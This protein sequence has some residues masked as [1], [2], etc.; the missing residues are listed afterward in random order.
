MTHT[1]KE[2]DAHE[3]LYKMDDKF[4]ELW[5]D[6]GKLDALANLI[7]LRSDNQEWQASERAQFAVYLCCGLI[8]KVFQDFSDVHNEYQTALTELKPQYSG[9]R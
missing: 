8:T 5:S 7:D 6:L 1:K 4:T 3:K 9:C 2:M